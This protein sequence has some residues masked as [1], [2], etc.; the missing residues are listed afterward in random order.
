MNI[1]T[2]ITEY[3]A[4]VMTGLAPCLGEWDESPEEGNTEFLSINLMGGPRPGVIARF[5]LIDLWYASKRGTQDDAGGKMRA[6]EKAASIAKYINDN[7]KSSCFANVI[8]ITDII[9]PKT[10]D[11]GRNIYKITL[12]VTV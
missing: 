8:P 11:E 7:P 4:P 2:H 6:Y 1:V 10:S 5:H 3:L 9:G 12:Q